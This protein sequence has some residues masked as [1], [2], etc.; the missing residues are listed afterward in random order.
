MNYGDVAMSFKLNF[1]ALCHVDNDQCRMPNLR[2]V[3]VTM[4]NL[5]LLMGG[6]GGGS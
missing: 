1:D 6:E 3:H 2:N 4:S 5:W